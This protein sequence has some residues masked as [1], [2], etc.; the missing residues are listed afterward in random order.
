M[1]PW[2]LLIQIGWMLVLAVVARAA[3][4]AGERRLQVVG[5]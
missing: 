4:G 2:L 5:G 1:E 3:F